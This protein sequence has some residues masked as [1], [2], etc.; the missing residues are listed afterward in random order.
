M[1]PASVQKVLTIP[2]AVD[3]LGMDYKFET[4]LYNINEYS[5]LIKLG[6][7]PY[8]KASDLKRLTKK[9]K[10]DV[11]QYVYIDDSITDNKTWGEGWQWD[12]DLN[13]SMA[14]FGAY[15]LDKNIIKITVIPDENGNFAKIINKSK[16]PLVFYNNVTSSGTTHLEVNRDLTISPNTIILSG[17]VSKPATLYIPVAN[18]KNYFEFQLTQALGNN[19]VYLKNPFSQ[20]KLSYGNKLEEKIEHELSTAI[21]DI[22]KN[23][24]NTVAETVFKISGG[25]TTEGGIKLFN[26]YCA[27]LKIDNSKIKITDGSGVSKNNL[28]TADFVTDYLNANSTNPIM[29]YLPKPGEGTLVQRMLPL[30]DNLKAKTG[31]LS[32][33]SALAGYL[34]TRA[35]NNYSFCIIQNDVKLPE[36]EKKMLEDYIIREAYLKL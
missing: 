20:R 9:V 31:T 15:N 13:P 26:E 17:T 7:D 33:V 8:L 18:L 28:V 25:G 11:T 4:G 1:N 12:D 29:N 27:K 3:K 10:P 2:A 36:T 6:A 22:F 32:G 23:S 34:T 14:R 5:Y 24:N 19:K 30:K 21:D 16:Y 35:G